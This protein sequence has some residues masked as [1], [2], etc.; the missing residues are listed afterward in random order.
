M[1]ALSASFANITNTSSLDVLSNSNVAASDPGSSS[2]SSFLKTV[3]LV[4]YAVLCVLG[5]VG[6]TMVFLASRRS[7]MTVVVSN[8]FIANL[9]IADL[10]VS[11]VN[12]PSVAAYAYL[13]YWPFGVFLC[14]CVSFLQGTT[15]CASV[16]TLVAIAAERYWHIVTYKRRKLTVRQVYKAIV[17]IWL[18]SVI[19]PSP[20]AVFSKTILWK[21]D[22][23]E[24]DICI[25]QWP[26]EKA[27]QLFSTMLSVVLYFIPLSLISVLYWKTG[28]FLRRLPV[29][30]KGLFA[31]FVCCFH[32][33]VSRSSKISQK[34]NF[35]FSKAD[36]VFCFLRNK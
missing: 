29:M 28:R 1:D 21:F 25:E 5:I 13:V 36:G 19:I 16:G 6:N 18:L 12:I 8:I 15:L 24:V 11:A 10:T 3:H 7:R 35:V 30:Q 17:I 22:G 33:F 4:S 32:F 26:N 2:T 31:L 9:T 23:K 34:L 14:K 27:R 20:I